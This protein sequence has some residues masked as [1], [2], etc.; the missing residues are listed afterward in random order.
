ML[1]LA[2]V[3]QRL[4]EQK[5]TDVCRLLHG[6]LSAYEPL[7]FAPIINLAKVVPGRNKLIWLTHSHAVNATVVLAI[8]I[9]P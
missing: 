3:L 7:R 1:I 8:E 4:P 2:R 9:G 5:L 6:A